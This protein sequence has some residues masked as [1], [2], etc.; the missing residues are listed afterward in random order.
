MM[1]PVA[2][3]ADLEGRRLHLSGIAGHLPL[4]HASVRAAFEAQEFDIAYQPILRACDLMPVACEALLRWDHPLKGPQ[5][6]SDFV[7][8]IERSRLALEVGDWLLATASRQVLA[9]ERAGLPA[10]RLAV[11]AAALQMQSTDFPSR[12][13]QILEAAD[14][15]ATRLSIEIDQDVLLDNPGFATSAFARLSSLGVSV[16]L[17]EFGGGPSTLTRLKAA[18]LGGFKL[19]R[20]FLDALAAG[21]DNEVRVL[22]GLASDMALRCVA[23]S[24]QTEAEYAAL[25][26]LGVDEVQGFLFCPPLAPEAFESFLRVHLRGVRATAPIFRED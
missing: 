25:R 26:R 16:E 20:R 1:S 17:D 9:W 8:I 21:F 18:A 6:P 11:N 22:A 4:C 13:Q 7:P 12:V 23:E 10:L 2:P 19:D 24:V 15:P 5:R 3:P 14:F